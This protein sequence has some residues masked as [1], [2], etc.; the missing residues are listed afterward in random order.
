MDG[1]ELGRRLRAERTATGRTIASV[2]ADAGL[3]VPYIANLE[4]GRG[5]PTVAA[6]ARLAEALG[7][8]LEVTLTPESTI[9]PAVVE[10]TGQA[11]RFVRSDRFRAELARLAGRTG[12]PEATVRQ[13]LIATLAATQAVT[14]VDLS[15]LDCHRVLD[16]L[17]L[18]NLTSDS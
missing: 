1:T 5:N 9:E 14:G 11:G 13:Q 17:V 6:L 12:T 4:N 3:S 18:I 7:V 2:A 15:T 10:L 8:H 16:T